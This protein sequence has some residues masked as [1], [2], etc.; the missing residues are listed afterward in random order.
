MQDP[1]IFLSELCLDKNDQTTTPPCC[2]VCY[3]DDSTPDQGYDV[4]EKQQTH[5]PI[6]CV[7]NFQNSL[8]PVSR[9]EESSLGTRNS[10][11]E[12][13]I[14]LLEE[15]KE[16]ALWDKDCVMDD[17]DVGYMVSVTSKFRKFAFVSE[18]TLNSRYELMSELLESKKLHKFFEA[19]SDKYFTRSTLANAND[20]TF[21]FIDLDDYNLTKKKKSYEKQKEFQVE[22]KAADENA[23]IEEDIPSTE[24]RLNAHPEFSSLGTQ[25]I[26]GLGSLI[27]CHSSV[28]RLK[29]TSKA[30][31]RLF[32]DSD[33]PLLRKSKHSLG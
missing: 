25:G 22:Y 31:K 19:E 24:P 13:S 26:K 2:S 4:R 15:L 28:K 10:Y 27:H 29:S 23:N 14:L 30:R 6:L 8:P 1:Q 18:V 16:L 5:T 3:E 11:G 32:V 33:E 20:A 12:S 17:D 7:M 9:E 21:K